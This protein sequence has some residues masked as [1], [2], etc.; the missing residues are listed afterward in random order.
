MKSY[1]QLKSEDA[2]V[3]VVGTDQTKFQARIPEMTYYELAFQAAKN[4]L[5]DANIEPGMID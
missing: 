5:A 4:A 2:R 3:A 1:S